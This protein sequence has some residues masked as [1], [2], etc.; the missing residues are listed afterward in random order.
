MVD[1]YAAKP[2]SKDR[3]AVTLLTADRIV[4]AACLLPLVGFTLAW[5]PAWLFDYLSQDNWSYVKFFLDWA[6][7]DPVLRQAMAV[8]YKGSRVAWIAPGFVAYHLLGPFFGSL[9]LN[10]TVA[11][12]T[13]L[14]TLAVTSR[15]FGRTAGALAT[16]VMSAYG[17]FYSSGHPGFW[18]YHGA[19]CNLFFT[20]Y[21]LG[22]ATLA[23]QPGSR[24]WAL[25]AGAA[26][27]LTVITS[28]NYLAAMGWASLSW[29]LLRGRPTLQE[30]AADL[31]AGAYG[32]ALAL[33]VLE[34]A[35]VLA[36]GDVWFL[37]P[38]VSA[39]LWASEGP[40]ARAP[41]TGWLPRSPH[42]A[43]PA[44]VAIGGM[45]T[46]V[47]RI[48]SLVRFDEDARAFLAAFVCF[49]GALGSHLYLHSR[50]GHF[51]DEPHFNVILMVPAALLVAGVIRW[52][53][54]A[55]NWDRPLPTYAYPLLAALLI[56]PQVV[57][58][59]AAL[60]GLD[61]RLAVL[62]A[63]WSVSATQF[64][65]VLA[66]I[67]ALA[68]VAIG[69]SRRWLG[70]A[71]LCLGVAWGLVNPNRVFADLPLACRV[72]VDNFRVVMD[73]AEW[74]GRQG[75]HVEPRTWFTTTD[76]L[77]RTDGCPDIPLAP[78]YLAVEQAAMVFRL[79]PPLQLTPPIS[80]FSPMSMRHEVETRQRPFFIILSTPEL[81]PALDRELVEWASSAQVYIRPR[82][83]RRETFTSGAVSLT[84]QVYGTGQ[85]ARRF[86]PSDNE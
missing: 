5:G 69:V 15:L 76:V 71:A 26:G 58:G 44:F 42:L 74:L 16:I 37:G 23:R 21:V 19:I 52:L 35:N 41:W 65:S 55:A 54:R 53:P 7:P 24:R 28:P 82:P 17:G 4:V 67:V 84:V 66:G 56:V 75:L 64:E 2:D 60:S 20:L 31:V 34:T 78:T 25:L 38:L 73:A 72:E 39:T 11:I 48:R 47:V 13:I 9:A 45:L 30:L 14:A 59:P 32:V 22:L 8:D 6:S 43:F 68:I 81:A 79:T 49:A 1:R 83:A 85:R 62:L 12:A 33:S 29:L 50:I 63:P 36:G 10:L 86:T 80:T 40:I 46:L 57:L 51:L 3:G 77:K 27:T 70:L 18:S 61:A